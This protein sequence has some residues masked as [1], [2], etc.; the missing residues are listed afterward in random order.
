MTSKATLESNETLFSVLAAINQCGYDDGLGDPVRAQVR[1]EMQQNV[2]AS[3]AATASAG[4]LCAFYDGHKQAD[5]GRNLA[6]FVSLAL[7]L[8]DAPDF[9]FAVPDKDIPPDAVGLADFVPLLRDFYQQA[10]LHAIYQAHERQEQQVLAQLHPPLAEMVNATDLYLKLP[11]SGYVGRRFSI[12]VEPMA[13]Y[14]QVNARNY[15]SDYLMVI[16]PAEGDVPLERIRHTYLHYV[17]D[18]LAMKHPEAMRRMLPLLKSVQS[19]PMDDS[20]KADTTLLAT[21]SLIRAIEARLLPG[22]KAVEGKREQMVNDDMAQG[23][24]LT[25]F[26]YDELL[27]FEKSPVSMTIGYGDMLADLHVDSEKKRAEETE[28][29]K[30]AAPS[31]EVQRTVPRRL[32]V[33]DQAEDMLIAKNVEGARKLA[34]SALDQQTDDPARAYFILA[35]AAS[36]SG[37]MNAAQDY[38]LRTLQASHDPRQIAWAHIYLGRIFDIQEKREIAVAHYKAALEAGDPAPDTKTAAERGIATPYEIPK[39]K[40]P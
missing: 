3:E 8:T 20:F 10:K 26:F 1:A 12:F 18:P 29:A 36:M 5:P 25:H 30:T 40:T 24:I 21:E 16:S 19:A 13:A 4:K 6:Q 32:S 33:L 9:H 23:F 27:Q 35:R 11:I 34:Q 22:G 15:R 7:N 17:L 28:F 39:A 38:F 37:D 2:H 31:L 14:G